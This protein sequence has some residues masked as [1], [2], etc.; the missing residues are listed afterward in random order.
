MYASNNGSVTLFA[1]KIEFH[2][3]LAVNLRFFRNYSFTKLSKSVILDSMGYPYL[4][5]FFTFPPSN[6][7]TKFLKRVLFDFDKQT[8]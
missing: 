6:R 7:F 1:I 5:E 8:V 4:G 2:L 3:N